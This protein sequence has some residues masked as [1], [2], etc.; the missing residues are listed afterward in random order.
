MTPSPPKPRK[1]PSQRRS[2]DTVET[3][4]EAAVRVLRR[5][6]YA[7]LTTRRVAEVAGVSV[8]SLYQYFPDRRAIVAELVR[9]RVDAFV[10]AV[11]AADVRGATD[12]RA[13]AE[14]MVTA[15]LA[16]KRASLW[17]SAVLQGAMGE[18]HGRQIIAERLRAAA[19]AISEKLS[20]AAGAPV[21]RR[22]LALG[23][24][25]IDGAIWEAAADDAEAIATPDF[26]DTLVDIL[27]AALGAS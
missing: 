13:A 11:E 15:F 9:R 12:L 27:L 24:S 3:I 17:L 10:A 18:V 22:K 1:S 6:G 2:I 14:A 16:E 8:G 26:R 20:L 25:A 23:L 21:D 19:P 7:G 4:M 5:D